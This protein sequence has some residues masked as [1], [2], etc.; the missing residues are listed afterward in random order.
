[1]SSSEQ[2]TEATPEAAAPADTAERMADAAARDYDITAGEERLVRRPMPTLDVVHD[3]FARNLRQGLFQLVSRSADIAIEPVQLLRFSDFLGALPLPSNFNIVAMPPLRGRAL[4]VCESTLISALVDALYGGSGTVH[5]PIEGRD[6]SPTE[7]RVIQRALGAI[8]Q[9]YNTAWQDVYPL[10]L[11][12]DRSETHVQF[13]DVAAPGDTVL[14]NLIKVSVAGVTGHI[15]V[16]LPYASLEPIRSVLYGAQQAR[17]MA[18]DRRWVTMLTREIQAAEVTLVAELAHPE[19]TVAQLMSMKPGDFIQ[20]DRLPQL[21]ASVEGAPV[22]ICHY[23]THNARYALRI[24]EC[25]RG[26]DPH[27]LGGSHVH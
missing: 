13:V 16:C 17:E 6:F 26:D 2:D 23:G 14:V 4:V 11:V 15:H 8:C 9:A 21:V 3:R 27:W 25:L 12:P 10:K 19:V 5:A 7:Q 20:F 22:F 18:E 24:D 1:M